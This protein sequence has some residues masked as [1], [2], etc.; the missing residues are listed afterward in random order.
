MS[1]YSDKHILD[2]ILIIL[3][4]RKKVS[5]ANPQYTQNFWDRFVKLASAHLVLPSVYSSIKSKRIEK[6]FPKDLMNYLK[7]ISKINYN[8]NSQILNQI[9]FLSLILKKNKINHVFLKGSA[10]IISN[11]YDA[12]NNRMIGDIDILVEK[13]DILKC[14]QLLLSKGF[15]ENFDEVE[16]TD[17][18]VN[19]GH[20][21]INRLVHSK[22]ISAVE[23]HSNLF[24][25]NFKSNILEP[26]IVLN[27]KLNT[28]GIYYIPSKIH[29][30]EHAILNW[31]INDRGNQL[32]YLSIRTVLDVFYLEP[33]NLKEK[34]KLSHK[35]IINFY[36]LISVHINEYSNGYRLNKTH[37]FLQLNSKTFN[38]LNK[39]YFKLRVFGNIFFSRIILIFTSK[40][41]RKR[42]LKNPLLIKKKITSF[43]DFKK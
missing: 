9:D 24:N 31:Q 14:K 40:K 30:W 23:I 8:R 1:K 12:L 34:L 26:S 16:L 17:G 2:F 13:K 19:K 29:Q 32:N 21:H 11:D 42:V 38:F 10:L 20:R 5:L 33:N 27:N 39:F 18:I 25:E 28:K 15:K 35:S 37:Y 3:H 7:E 22:F 43:W 36:D 6:Y 4:P 41:Y